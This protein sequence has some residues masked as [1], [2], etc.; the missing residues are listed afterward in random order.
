MGDHP[1]LVVQTGDCTNSLV[2]GR[3]G[4]NRH[5]KCTN[6]TGASKRTDSDKATVCTNG[7]RIGADSKMF[8]FASERWKAERNELQLQIGSVSKELFTIHDATF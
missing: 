7:T 3:P 1:N 6:R 8:G 4:E 2:I 5:S